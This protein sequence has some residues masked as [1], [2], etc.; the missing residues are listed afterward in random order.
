M[1]SNIGRFR[2]ISVIS[3]QILKYL[4]WY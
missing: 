2:Y 1:V 3:Y 4:I